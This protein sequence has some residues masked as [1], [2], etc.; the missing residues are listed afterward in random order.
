MFRRDGHRAGDAASTNHNGSLA[1]S[2]E[3]IDNVTSTTPPNVG[4]V[5]RH[6]TYVPSRSARPTSRTRPPPQSSD[7]WDP[8]AFSNTSAIDA[9]T[10][11]NPP[12]STSSSTQHPKSIVSGSK[13]LS[14]TLQFAYQRGADAA[15]KAAEQ[16]AAD[17]AEAVNIIANY[18]VAPSEMLHLGRFNVV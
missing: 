18:A 1:S 9:T 4:G 7:T 2:S 15:T 16:I 10:T 3:R 11:A 5:N 6:A 14:P 8:F 12:F 13:L 17:Q